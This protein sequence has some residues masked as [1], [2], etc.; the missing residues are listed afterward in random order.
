MLGNGENPWMMKKYAPRTL[1]TTFASFLSLG[2]MLGSLVFIIGTFIMIIMV[3]IYCEDCDGSS[4]QSG[5]WY[6]AGNQ[7][8]FGLGFSLLFFSI[9]LEYFCIKLWKTTRKNNM[10]GL[11]KLVKIGNFALAAFEFIACIA[12]T[13]FSYKFYQLRQKYLGFHVIMAVI[14]GLYCLVVC[15]KIFG[16]IKLKPGLIQASLLFNSVTVILAFMLT[17]ISPKMFVPKHDQNIKELGLFIVWMLFILVSSV[18]IYFNCFILLLYNVVL[19][20]SIRMESS[21]KEKMEMD[22]SLLSNPPQKPGPCHLV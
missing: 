10:D 15:L 2:G 17:L 13:I 20:E 11:I 16:T 1:I 12:L 22:G 6:G 4:R 5:L 9:G 8:M 21:Q 3:Q 18:Y 19:E 7:V 14:T